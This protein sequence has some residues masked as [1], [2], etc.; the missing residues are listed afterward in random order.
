M[1]SESLPNKILKKRCPRCASEIIS[2][3]PDDDFLKVTIK[4]FKLIICTAC[5]SFQSELNRVEELERE[6]WTVIGRLDKSI[7]NIKKARGGGSR[8]STLSIKIAKKEEERK[9]ARAGLQKLTE[10]KEDILNRRALHEQQLKKIT[11]PLQP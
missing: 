10:K 4:V 7:Y 6:S 5:G 1:K 9:T 2:H 11:T 3:A 8:D